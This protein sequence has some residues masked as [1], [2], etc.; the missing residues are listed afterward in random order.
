MAPEPMPPTEPGLTTPPGPT[1]PYPP[2]V[3]TMG[4]TPPPT[5][6]AP[7]GPVDPEGGKRL[8]NAGIGTMAGGGV[9]AALGFGLTLAFTIQGRKRH[10]ELVLVEDERQRKDCSRQGSKTCTALAAQ[11][12]DLGKQ[13]DSA[14]KNGQVGGALM[15]TGFVV[16]AVGGLVYRMGIR[17]L[18][19]PSLGRVKISPSLG[20]VV[21]SGRF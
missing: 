4:P 12:A 11:I 6:S 13:M 9:I 19:P 18:Q 10:D 16:L 8:R 17:K 5:P 1:P 14:N 7:P 2:P 15:L 3:D 21:L 20:G